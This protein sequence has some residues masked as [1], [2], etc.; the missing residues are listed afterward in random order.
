MSNYE[1]SKLVYNQG[2]FL[3][4]RWDIAWTLVSYYVYDSN[5]TMHWSIA[6]GIT[7][8]TYILGNM[9]LLAVRNLMF[10]V[11]EDDDTQAFQ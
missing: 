6:D 2:Q 11:S 1:F 10:C 7:P 4:T 8:P 3:D 9:S 5:Q